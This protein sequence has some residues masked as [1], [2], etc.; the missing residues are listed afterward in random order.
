MDEI[1][2]YT[3]ICKQV[4]IHANELVKKLVS[5]LL[6]MFMFMFMYI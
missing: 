6:F 5:L 3:Q 4:N 1:N 2:Y